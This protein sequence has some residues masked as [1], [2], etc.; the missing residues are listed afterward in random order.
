MQQKLLKLLMFV[1]KTACYLFILQLTGLQLL[2][3]ANTKGQS[4]EKITISL[5]LQNA[6]LKEAFDVIASKTNLH[7]V[8]D[9]AISGID[10][11]LDLS[12]KQ[13]TLKEVL[14]D[15]SQEAGLNFK[16]INKTISVTKAKSKKREKSQRSDQVAEA[17]E[18]RTISGKVTDENGEPLAGATIQVKGRLQIGTVT[19]IEGNFVLSIPDD[20]TTLIFTYVGFLSQEVDITS[21]SVVQVTLQPDL[22]ALE[23]VQVVS[24]GYYEVEKTFATTNTTK[25]TSKDI[26]KQPVANVVQ[27]LQ[28]LTTGVDIQQNSGVP[29]SRFDIRIR[30]VNS[31]RTGDSNNGNQPLIILDG[32]P[33]PL[34]RLDQIS[35]GI[36]LNVGGINPLNF[37]NPNDIE[38]IEILKDAD[39]TAIYG[40]RGANGVILIKSKKG[41]PGKPKFTINASTGFGELA[42]KFDVMNTEQ[43]LTMRREAFANDGR[44]PRDI[45]FDVNGTW[46]ESRNTDWQEELLDGRS[47][48]TNVR[49]SVSGGSPQSAFFLGVNYFKETTLFS[50]EFFDR[51]FSANYNLS[52]AS[53]DERLTVNFGGIYTINNNRLFANNLAAQAVSLPPNAPQL[54]NEDGSLNWENGT[55]ENPLAG[56]EQTN[57]GDGQNFVGNLSIS[58]EFLEGLKVLTTLSYNDVRLDQISKNPVSSRNPFSD[59]ILPASSTFATSNVKTWISEP[60]I[61]YDREIGKGRFS[62]LMGGTFQQTNSESERI[63]ATEYSSDALL[64]N[65]AAAGETLN[66]FNNSE[67]RFNSVFGRVNYNYDRRYVINFTARRDGSSRFG[68]GRQFAN[69]F[70][71]GGA[72][73]FSGESFISD[74]LSFLSFGKLRASYGTTGSDA[75]GNYQ[76]LALWSPTGLQ[77]DGTNG[78]SPDNLFNEDF[79][80]EETRKLEMGIDAGFVED[81]INVSVS[82]YRN[83]SDNQLIGEPLALTTGFSTIQAN[84]PALVRNWGWEVELNT[85]NIKTGEFNWTTN[86]NITIPR[87][88]LVEFEDIENSSFEDN[89]LVG[90]SIISDLVFEYNGLDPETGLYTFKDLNGDG[91]LSIPEDRRTIVDLQDRFRG[92]LQNTLNYKGFSLSFLIRFEDKTSRNFLFDARPGGFGNQSTAFLTRWQNPGDQVAY[93]RPSQ[94][95]AGRASIS[96]IRGS[97]FAYSDASFIRLQN[98]SLSYSLS[99]S[100]LS[101]AKVDACSVFIQGQNLAT[102][103]DYLGWDPETTSSSALP[104]LRTITYGINVT[105]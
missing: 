26:E 28:G 102:L 27:T 93:G 81:R 84:F 97:N 18:D 94:T 15:I 36:S 40:S 14:Q 76:Y 46:D 82:Y 59:P 32:V 72:W 3:A 90:E 85:V 86:F 49:A 41:T 56:F 57:N 48:F 70:A 2:M 12:Y 83:E 29:G 4:L 44:E 66:A 77:Y 25:I 34:E 78:L 95:G 80:W 11:R 62:A 30:G 65:P 6:T 101:K 89:Y 21:S 17:V 22:R 19:D 92:G 35:G 60:Q 75:I 7:F 69:F 50:D 5:E 73:I 9:R 38:S 63:E 45:D 8:H 79:A 1:S 67:Y 31:L 98:V 39:A 13:A 74:N 54:R 91:R 43:Y 53:S 104:P 96:N 87:N 37:I 88:E 24:T 10:T 103:T 33:Y 105:F 71:V 52:H 23:E 58:Y 55:F 99:K 64:E 20:A 42:N 51:K 16:L 68:P 47:N 100:I 61:S